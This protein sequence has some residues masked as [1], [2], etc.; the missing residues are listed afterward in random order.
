MAYRSID[1]ALEDLVASGLV[2]R[3]SFGRERL[4]RLSSTHRLAPIVAGLFHAEADFYPALRVA[5]RAVTVGLHSELL[6]VAIVGPVARHLERLESPV[7]LLILATTPAA[8]TAWE[9]RFV[10]A[11]ADM[12]GRFGA[13]LKPIAY[14]LPTARNMWRSRTPAAERAVRDAESVS[15]PPILTLLSAPE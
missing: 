1:L 15:G 10:A 8:A 9:H 12:L 3:T 2:E 7:E 5:L 13:D 11:G 6:A 14:D 4:V